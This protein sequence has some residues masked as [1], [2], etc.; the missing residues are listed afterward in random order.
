M[1][2]RERQTETH[3]QTERTGN[4]EP[5]CSFFILLSPHSSIQ[6]SRDTGCFHTGQF[7]WTQQNRDEW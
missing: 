3:R 1:K 7:L 5:L 4:I 6:S 2:G